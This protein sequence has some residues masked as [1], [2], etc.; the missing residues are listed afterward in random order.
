MRQ[1]T[2][3]QRSMPQAA[4]LHA[5]VAAAASDALAPVAD[6]HQQ[7]AR[8]AST[9]AKGTKQA[10]KIVSRLPCSALSEV[11]TF[12]NALHQVCCR[13]RWPGRPDRR[14]HAPTCAPAQAR[15]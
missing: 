9:A 5:A 1:R 14:L 15:T 4:L 8:R 10:A 6:Q 13:A 7:A 11:S 3:E 12:G 2:A